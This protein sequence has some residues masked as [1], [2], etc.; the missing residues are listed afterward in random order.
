MG[1]KRSRSSRRSK[2]LSGEEDLSEM[3]L[4]T[5]A[6]G[7]DTLVNIEWNAQGTSDNGA[8]RPQ[9]IEPSQRSNEIKAWTKNFQQKNDDIINKIIEEMEN[10][11]HVI[12]KAIKYNKS[13]TMATN[14][15]SETNDTRNMQPSESR[16]DRSN[17]LT[18]CTHLL[19]EIQ[20]QTTRI[21]FLRHLK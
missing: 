13:A 10:K 9:L 6:Q 4:E 16:T 12:L 1:N 5:S 17:G 3:Q 8:I 2:T 11:I 7:K 20:T 19:T 14:S 21:I 18:E 15:R